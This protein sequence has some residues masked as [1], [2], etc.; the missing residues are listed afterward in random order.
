M[1]I[2]ELSFSIQDY[3]TICFIWLT[4]KLWFFFYYYFSWLICI[5]NFY[6]FTVYSIYNTCEYKPLHSLF[7]LHQL[8][9]M[10]DLAVALR[11]MA[12]ET[13]TEWSVAESKHFQSINQSI[14][15]LIVRLLPGFG[16]SV[17]T[18]CQQ[19]IV[20]CAC[21]YIYV[22]VSCQRKMEG[23]EVS[24]FINILCCLLN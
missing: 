17:S 6:L 18:L 11:Y 21:V 7:T 16:A 15:C 5:F 14:L 4:T 19:W 8:P 23:T 1:N 24:L 13:F 3:V 10:F 12:F 9:S 2:I 22:Q 20:Q